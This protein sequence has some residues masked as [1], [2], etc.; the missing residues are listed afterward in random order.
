[1]IE[2]ILSK[3]IQQF[4]RS[5]GWDDEHK[6]LLKYRKVGDLP[7]S[8]VVDQ[9]VGK[10]KAKDKLPTFYQTEG[11]V[12]PPPVNI[13]QSSSEAT[14]KFKSSIFETIVDKHRAV[15]L[16]GG[17]GIDTLF[18]S[19]VFDQ[20]S[21]IEPDEYLLE[22]AKHNHVLLGQQNISYYK[23]T[24]EEFLQKNRSEVDLVYIDP[25]RRQPHSKKAFRFGECE[26]DITAL[27][28]Q[29]FQQ[30]NLLLIKASPLMDIQQ[31]IRELKDV[32][33]VFVVSVNN[34]AKEL[35]FLCEKGFH[36][37]PAIEAINIKG[38]VLESFSFYLSHEK[39][40]AVRLGDPSDYLYEPNASILKAGAF[41]SIAVK[42]DLSK[43]DPNTHLYTT[44][45]FI[46]SFPGKIFKVE[47]YTKPDKKSIE[48][49]LPDMKANIVV[50]N[51][52]LSTTELKKKI[53]LSD[54]GDKY[55]VGFS[56][57]RKK[58]LAVAVRVR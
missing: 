9:I 19:K 25:S 34:D 2:K 22:I 54:G 39:V 45:K 6:L 49:H 56:S 13:E 28:G 35:L 52:P 14:A 16:T 42:F 18:L 31:G 57:G 5:H 12:Y 26:P 53:K 32:K 48:G 20:V 46:T 29:I 11:I 4:V 15:D 10:R 27:I 1:M 33:S 41:K 50:R 23:T 51:Y 30:S 24:A 58:H 3:E 21:Y 38:D 44:N 37:E 8:M 40:L 47:M 7:I 17:L 43:L 36:D 55:L